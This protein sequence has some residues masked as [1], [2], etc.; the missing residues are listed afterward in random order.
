MRRSPSSRT[1]R[2]VRG[3]RAG[4][5]LLLA[6]ALLSGCS[7]PQSALDPAGPSARRL[8]TLWWALFAVSAVVWLVVVLCVAWAVLRRRGSEVTPRAGG[9]RT[10][11]VAG[12]V[13]P[14]LVLVGT[15]VGT[16]SVM[17]AEAEPP[18]EPALTI[19]V[20]GHLW[21][22]EVRYPDFVTANELH[23]P[24]GRS[25]Q[26]ELRTADVIHSFWVPSLTSKVD[27]IPNQNNELWL[28]AD[29]AGEYRGQCA[30]F[31]GAQHAGM[32]FLVIAEPADEFDDWLAD[33][34]RPAETPT[35]PLALRGR[36]V[37]ESQ[38]CA[39]CH[40]VRG[41]DADGDVGPDLTH[42][43]SRRTLGAGVAPNEPGWLGGWISNSQT[44][45]PGNLMP[46]QPLDPVD[47]TALIAY[48]ETLE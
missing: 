26:V 25:V 47:L 45:K 11:V 1:S 22:W 38:S 48:L 33:Q 30:E 35:D 13:I 8:A 34:A 21:W 44:I 20:I 23:I 40:T 46:P 5:L 15:F 9:T 28:H 36:E 3:G 39:A 16:V 32:S 12:I 37:L 27:L 29:E 42:F 41:T 17:R 4:A 7:S 2:G 19:E 24:V 14:T 18:T 31:C 10:V 6:V 43:G